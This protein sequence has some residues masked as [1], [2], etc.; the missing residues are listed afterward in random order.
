MGPFRRTR[1]EQPSDERGTD[2]QHGAPE[3]RRLGQALAS[4]DV[5][6]TSPEGGVRVPDDARLRIRSEA[7]TVTLDPTL[8]A[9]ELPGTSNELHRVVY[10]TELS[11]VMFGDA[12]LT[13]LV[14]GTELELPELTAQPA[15]HPSDESEREPT[16]AALAESELRAAVAEL[17]ERWRAAEQAAADLTAEGRRVGAAVVATLSQVRR[18]RQE[19]LDL[20]A[21]ATAELERERGERP[22]D[23]ASD[24][25]E[26]PG[27]T[28]P[29]FP[30]RDLL[31]R[32][33]SA[34]SAS[35]D[36]DHAE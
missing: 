12:A 3:Y 30:N 18:E 28:D 26:A 9:V 6:L 34:R 14:D 15:R 11:R 31:A 19:L 24:E 27:G 8:I 35:S 17:E 22:G 2:W 25:P 36:A 33:E 21:R 13:L 4:V 20:L 16:S 10:V 7:G 29:W 32:I 5:T 23:V 1:D